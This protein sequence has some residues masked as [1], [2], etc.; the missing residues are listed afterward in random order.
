MSNQK[1]DAGQCPVCKSEMFV[2]GINY[3]TSRGLV[4]SQTCKH[5]VESNEKNLNESGG[6]LNEVQLM[7]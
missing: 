1:G 3:Q 5:Y 2:L 7:L 4:C 6:S